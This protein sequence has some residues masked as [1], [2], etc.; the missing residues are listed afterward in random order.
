MVEPTVFIVDDDRGVR[1]SIRE[2]LISVGLAV[3]TTSVRK[4]GTIETRGRRPG[5]GEQAQPLDVAIRNEQAKTG[6]CP[7]R[8][9]ETSAQTTRPAGR[10]LAGGNRGRV[11]HR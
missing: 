3:E 8:Q 6:P 10:D 5:S 4:H 7:F 9:V 11:S 1:N 2:L